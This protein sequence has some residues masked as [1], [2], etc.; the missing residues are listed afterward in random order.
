MYI[1][2]DMEEGYYIALT[3]EESHGATI[4]RNQALGLTQSDNIR[5]RNFEMYISEDMEEGYYIALTGEESSVPKTSQKTLNLLAKETPDNKYYKNIIGG[6]LVIPYW[7]VPDCIEQFTINA[8]TENDPVVK[9]AFI[10]ALIVIYKA[11]S[12]KQ[13]Y[14]DVYRNCKP[15]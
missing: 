14:H 11:L 10:D 13:T 3:G 9:K 7:N 12:D 4:G 5:D 1:S 6:N 15:I 8:R 2:E